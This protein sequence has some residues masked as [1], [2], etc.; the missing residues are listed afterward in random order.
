MKCYNKLSKKELIGFLVL[1]GAV[2]VVL[3]CISFCVAFVACEELD[4]DL[5]VHEA[6]LAALPLDDVALLLSEIPIGL[7]QVR[8]VHDAV[9][10][11]SVNGYDEE[12]MMRN[13]F[14][15]PGTGVGEDRIPDKVMES[16]RRSGASAGRASSYTRPLKEL[17][18]EHLRGGKSGRVRMKSGEVLSADDILDGRTVEEY[19]QILQS[20]D[21]Q[22]YWPYYEDWDGETYPVITFDPMD[23]GTVNDGY[24]VERNDDGE[25]VLEKILVNEGT[26]QKRPVWVVNRNDDSEYT[27]LELLRMEDPDWGSGGGDII[28]NPRKTNASGHETKSATE[29]YESQ[30]LILKDFTM[31]RHFDS[32]FAGAS[33]FFVKIGS[34]ENFTASTEAE[35]L[36]Y[37]PSITDFMIVVKR[38]NLGKPQPFNAVLVSEWTEQLTACAFMV[39]EDDGGKRDSWKCS[40]MVKYNSKSYGF[41]MSIPINTRDDIVWRGQLSRKYII[42][43]DGLPSHFGDVDITFEIV[44]L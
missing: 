10:S 7:E 41:E 1:N 20:S 24:S 29:S 6:E 18:E 8:E 33:E 35:L 22:I 42:A 28:I 16:R 12:Y 17:I 19:L 34:V 43:N 9:S 11:S 3:L 13:L 32:W 5:S 38:K 25:L 23:G 4:D 2:S 36:L 27:S 30:M 31:R 21:I 40:A 26:A 44:D 15:E 39:V 14:T 37:T